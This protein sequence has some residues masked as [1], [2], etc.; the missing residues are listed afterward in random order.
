MPL[1][2]KKW[3]CSPSFCPW[4]QRLPTDQNRRKMDLRRLGASHGAP[5]PSRSSTAHLGRNGRNGRR[6]GKGGSQNVQGFVGR[7]WHV[8]DVVFHVFFHDDMEGLWIW[9]VHSLL[10][11]Q[12]GSICPEPWLQSSATPNTTA[13]SPSPSITTAPQHLHQLLLV[14][15]LSFSLT[16]K[17]VETGNREANRRIPS[18][19]LGGTIP[20]KN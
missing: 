17:M 10:D 14:P 19:T 6:V 7:V 16:S 8:L 5:R 15:H 11:L 12:Y 9:N 4:S 18:P 1:L 20:I 3:L 13:S 2:R